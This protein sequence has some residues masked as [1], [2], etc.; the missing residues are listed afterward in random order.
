VVKSKII[1]FQK[2]AKVSKEDMDDDWKDDGSGSDNNDDGDND[3]KGSSAPA[4]RTPATILRLPISA[5]SHLSRNNACTS[6]DGDAM[7]SFNENIFASARTDLLVANGSRVSYERSC[8]PELPYYG[9]LG[10]VSKST[11]HDSKMNVA[12]MSIVTPKYSPS[13]YTEVYLQ[14]NTRY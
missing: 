14:L 9:R 6:S 10:P 7:G 12:D 13:P 11:S 2:S 1:R 3:D 8:I 4:Q 5:F